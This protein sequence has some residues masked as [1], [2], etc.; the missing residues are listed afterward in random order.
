MI[1]QF[2]YVHHLMGY[3]VFTMCVTQRL[4]LLEQTGTNLGPIYT[5][6]N[7]NKLPKITGQSRRE[8]L[9]TFAEP[10]VNDPENLFHII[11][12]SKSSEHQVML[13]AISQ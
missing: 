6:M 7:E 13:S 4:L 12:I 5:Q 3:S 1:K 9:L 8:T 11:S 10:S 2:K